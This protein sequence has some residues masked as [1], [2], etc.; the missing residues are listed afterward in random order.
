MGGTARGDGRQGT[1]EEA[2]AAP[3]THRRRPVA[4]LATFGSCTI[5]LKPLARVHSRPTVP[6]ERGV[7]RRGAVGL[8]LLG[9]CRDSLWLALGS[10]RAA[11]QRQQQQEP[12][13][14]LLCHFSSRLTHLLPAVEGLGACA[15]CLPRCRGAE[16]QGGKRQRRG[17]GGGN[18]SLLQS[19]PLH[20]HTQL[21]QITAR[22]QNGCN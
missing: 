7:A 20:K 4:R 8:R 17:G 22:R 3:V 13:L 1:R 11:G 2:P 18:Y 19:K 14:Q 6:C 10:G 12:H 5:A 16:G 21:Q 9:S 15:C